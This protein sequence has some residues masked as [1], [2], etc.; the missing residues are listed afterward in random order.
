MQPL[1]ECVPNFSEGRDLAV[2]KEITEAIGSVEGVKLLDVDP[3]HATNRT[4]VT[5]VGAPDDV[6]EAA[7]LGIQKA[8]ELIDMTKHRGAHPR[9]GATD[10]C[11]MIPISGITIEETVAY[12]KKLGEK[13]G[14]ELKVPVYLYEAAA[15]SSDRT[16][17]A[18]I[19]AGE[20]EGF[21]KKIKEKRK[22]H[23]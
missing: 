12:A 14:K 3:G 2:I 10:V 7:F 21:G 20:Y 19:R 6:V 23:L 11:P 22:H 18:I 16:N 1:I 15:T 13:V 9:M 5:F 4:V 8:A 17:L